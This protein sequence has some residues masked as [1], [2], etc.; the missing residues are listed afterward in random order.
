MLLPLGYH[1]LEWRFDW[2]RLYS[3]ASGEPASKMG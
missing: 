2:S 1:S 3:C